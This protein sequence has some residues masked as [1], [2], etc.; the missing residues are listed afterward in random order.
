MKLKDYEEGLDKTF[1]RVLENQVEIDSANPDVAKIRNTI[2][3]S[4]T[5]LKAIDTKISLSKELRASNAK[6][7]R[8]IHNMN[9]KEK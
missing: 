1:K 2:N 5:V 6:Q 3:N 8:D 7:L 9:R 4:N